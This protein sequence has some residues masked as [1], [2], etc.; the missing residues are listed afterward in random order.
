MRDL[1]NC[2]NCA[3][4]IYSDICPYCGSVFL[5]WAAFDTSKP[6]FVK[7][8]DRLTGHYRLLKLG[9]VSASINISDNPIHLYADNEV[10]C[11]VQSNPDITIEAE[12]QCY[13]FK[14]ALTGNVVNCIDID[15]DKADRETVRQV[16][17]GI[18]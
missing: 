4:P 10:Y 11:S 2:P 5:D 1:L 16:L 17:E 9:T 14:E 15:P 6:T 8:K 18:K 3:A 12:F 13:P 7:V